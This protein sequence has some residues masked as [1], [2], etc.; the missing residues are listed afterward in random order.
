[1]KTVRVLNAGT[2]RAVL[3]E[4]EVAEGAWARFRGLMGRKGLPAGRGLIIPGCH[5]IHTCF[6]RFAMDAVYLDGGGRIVRIVD[7]MKPWRLSWCRGAKSVLEM[8]SGAAK[9]A[10]LKPGDVLAFQPLDPARP[11]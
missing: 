1:M 5:G 11:A 2:G 6:M 3:E 4:A 7:A 8:T 9:A 10:G